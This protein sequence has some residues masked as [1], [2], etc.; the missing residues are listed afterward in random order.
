MDEKPARPGN[1]SIPVV[2]N[3][4][5][6][7]SDSSGISPVDPV[8]KIYGVDRNLYG[9]KAKDLYS[10]DTVYSVITDSRDI[11]QYLARLLG[12][13]TKDGYVPLATE[14]ESVEPTPGEVKVQVRFTPGIIGVAIVNPEVEVKTLRKKKEYRWWRQILSAFLRKS[15]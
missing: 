12:G 9:V 14:V 11:G 5:L 15:E 4:D 6:V 10:G 1:E 2:L 3:I 7:V 13:R 8:N